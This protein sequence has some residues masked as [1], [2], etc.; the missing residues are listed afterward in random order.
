MPL[1]LLR[2]LLAAL[3]GS[4][5]L[6]G[7]L[8]LIMSFLPSIQAATTLGVSAML[9]FSGMYILQHFYIN[10]V[11]RALHADELTQRLPVSFILST[12]GETLG[13]ILMTTD[14]TYERNRYLLGIV[15]LLAS[16]FFRIRCH[17]MQHNHTSKIKHVNLNTDSML[18][19]GIL[20]EAKKFKTGWRTNLLVRG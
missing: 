16:A 15:M 2:I 7:L 19:N 14:G 8:F 18:T 12:I 3:I 13:V 6:F 11:G 17:V 1:S 20:V 5:A 4:A 9:G 10:T